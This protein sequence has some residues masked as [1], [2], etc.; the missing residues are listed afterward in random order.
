MG[1]DRFC[2]DSCLLSNIFG[3]PQR[4]S[5]N[6]H[7]E[8]FQLSDAIS[9]T[10]SMKTK[11]KRATSSSSMKKRKKKAMKLMN[12]MNMKY[13][14]IQKQTLCVPKCNCYNDVRNENQ[15]AMS[16]QKQLLTP[17]PFLHYCCSVISTTKRNIN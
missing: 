15:N 9:S 2:C 1:T 13:E 17:P 11:K 6:C 12:K 7:L 10:S 16:L 5:R 4:H 14:N 3:R 8:M